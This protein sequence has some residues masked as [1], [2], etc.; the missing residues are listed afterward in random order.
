MSIEV[1]FLIYALLFKL[2][3]IASGLLCIF[4]GYR[5]FVALST[6]D[7]C[8]QRKSD[9]KQLNQQTDATAQIGK[10][11]FS[12][13]SAAPGTSFAGFGV[14]L[15][16]SMLVTTPPSLDIPKIE[17]NQGVHRTLKLRSVDDK[18]ISFPNYSKHHAEFKKKILTAA[19][20]LYKN[21]IQQA[22]IVFNSAIQQ[23][24]QKAENNDYRTAIKIKN[25]ALNI[26]SFALNNRAYDLYEKGE[27][28]KALS[29]AELA[30]SISHDNAEI[31]KTL[32]KIQ[33]LISK[34]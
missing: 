2:S 11:K 33:K 7:S 24:I 13:K 32:F 6:I 18:K 31:Q 22:N 19:Q 26:Y 21:K 28:P 1:V 5:L 25:E 9:S 30:A 29:L 14:I 12:F 27:L 8:W 23:A 3:I 34:E 16:I 4:L 20:S 17:T 15:I 10:I